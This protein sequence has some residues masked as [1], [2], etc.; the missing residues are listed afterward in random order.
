MTHRAHCLVSGG[1]L[2]ND[3]NS[4]H[5][6]PR[7]RRREER[8]AALAPAFRICGSGTG[9][10]NARPV[11]GERACCPL[12]GTTW[13]ILSFFD[14]NVVARGVV[15]ARYAHNLAVRTAA[16]CVINNY[17]RAGHDTEI[18]V[19]R[20]GEAGGRYS[21]IGLDGEGVSCSLN[22]RSVFC[23]RVQN[24]L[25]AIGHLQ[26]E[27]AFFHRQLKNPLGKPRF[28]YIRNSSGGR[29]TCRASPRKVG[30]GAGRRGICL[31]RSCFLL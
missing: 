4:L 18:A 17:L 25:I 11:V 19:V 13:C 2:L 28:C 20:A 15:P 16:S 30:K 7:A 8:L 1:A 31:W 27:I 21:L 26:R 3:L 6:W 5:H 10:I 22:S 24:R 14:N 12:R 29:G 9:V 23:R